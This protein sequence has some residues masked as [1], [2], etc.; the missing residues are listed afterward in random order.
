MIIRLKL[1]KNPFS[2]T[3]NF[4]DLLSCNCLDKGCNGDVEVFWLFNDGDKTYVGTDG[5]LVFTLPEGASGFEAPQELIPDYRFL[6]DNRVTYLVPFP[7]GERQLVFSY[8]LAKP[9]SA[10]FTIPLEVD[11]PTGSFVLMLGGEYVEVATNQ[12]APAEPVITDTGE[13]FIHFRG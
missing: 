2:L 6:D 3:G 10:E 7:P 1:S 11:Y 8:R 4:L 9:D 5:V 12:L 13:R